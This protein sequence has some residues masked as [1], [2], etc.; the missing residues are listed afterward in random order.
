MHK[1]LVVEDEVK[2][3]NAVKQGLEE[4]GFE[5]DVAYDGRMGKSLASNND[6]DLVILDLNLPHANGY[7]LC[8]VIRRKNSRVPIIM[9]TALGGVEDKMQAFELGADDYLVK[10]FDFR[11]LLAR[12]R[13]FLKRMGTDAPLNNQYKIVIADLEI[14]R[15]KKEV[16][17][18]GNK[19]ALTAKEYQLLEFLALHKGKVISKLTIAEKV[20]DIN[21]DTGTNVIEVYMN[22]L[23]KKI[24]KDFDN[25]LLHTKTGMGYY[26]EEG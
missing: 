18:G 9:L 25:K 2:V 7:E 4:N 24:D 11:E 1:L 14:D 10:P 22:F 26:L 13:V 15:E 17:R 21:F 8:E 19:I 12:I 3:A 16:R 5:V 20:W 23:R 6:Y